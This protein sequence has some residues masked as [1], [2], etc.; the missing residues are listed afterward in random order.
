[1]VRCGVRTSKRR[2]NSE[3]T[4]WSGYPEKKQSQRIVCRGRRAEGTKAEAIR[5]CKRSIGDNHL[6]ERKSF[7]VFGKSLAKSNAF[8]LRL[9]GKGVRL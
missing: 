4:M 5:A 8:K 1:M 2:R 3:N 6:G 7:Y 9:R